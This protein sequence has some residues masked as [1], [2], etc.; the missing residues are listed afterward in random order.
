M[1]QFIRKNI[2]KWHKIIGLIT[3]IPVI[4][5]C[6]SGL[7]HPFLAHWFKPQIAHEFIVPKPLQQDDFKLTLKE[8][9]TKNNIQEF[10]NCR[11]VEFKNSI[12]YQVKSTSGDWQYFNAKTGVLLHDGDIKYAEHLARYFLA[13]S[14]SSI[15][16][17]AQVTEFSQQYKY[18]NRLL[19]VWK[20]SF[21]RSDA[22]DVYIETP[23]SRLGTYNPTS[24]KV[25]L[26]VF[27]NFHNWTFL[28][29]ISNNTLK[30]AIMLIFLS[31]IVISSLS[32][33]VIYGFMWS[34]FKKPDPENKKGVLKKYHRQIGISVA[35]VLLTFAFSGG[36]HATRKLE[37]NVLP[38]MVYETTFET[39]ELN[40]SLLSKQLDWNRLINLSI[41]KADTSINYQVFYSETENEPS[42]TIYFNATNYDEWKN[43]DSEYAIYLSKVF[44]QKSLVSNTNKACC[45]F[46]DVSSTTSTGRPKV[47][48][49]ELLPNFEMREYGFAFKRLPVIRVSFD[50]PE[51]TNYYIETTTSRLSAKIEN[52]DRYE[53]YSF[54]IF[55]KF[56]FIDWAGKNA[57]DI[58][59]ILSALGI[60]TVCILGLKLYLKK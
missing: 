40:D 42:Q 57:R 50:T 32:G 31:I 22:M 13:D 38:Q 15:K 4:F 9:L 7:M 10:K 3:I 21:E 60:L 6:L 16:S 43:G 27:D 18:I 14:T 20:V 59:M 53:G 55:H 58:L 35:F 1:K 30:I 25:F 48:K 51:L 44:Q 33:I 54:A 24:R 26:W 39:N 17:I 2:Y 36:Y 47:L 11:L 56:L 8:V 19:P 52:A 49:T 37:P 23:Y 12:Y 5:W 29:T 46:G 28:S 45:E 34:K 41:V